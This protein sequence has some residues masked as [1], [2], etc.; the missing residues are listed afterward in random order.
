[1]D[2]QAALRLCRDIMAQPGCEINA[3]GENT[4]YVCTR[5]A[6][7][8]RHMREDVGNNT[9][10]LKDPDE[11]PEEM[12]KVSAYCRQG[13]AAVITEL[14]E[15]WGALFQVAVAGARWIDFTVADKGFG[16]RLIC[17]RLGIDPQEVMS[18]GDNYNDIPILSLVGQP[19]IMENAV[20][21][22]R[23][24]FPRHCRRVEDILQ[25]L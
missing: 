17:R 19:Y 11:I 20:P 10:N 6:E 9:V 7:Y 14:T 24:M 12:I 3:S 4:C 25:M 1:M 22:L 16:L 23:A 21:E 5:D 13:T 2:R 18:F 8:L 15:R